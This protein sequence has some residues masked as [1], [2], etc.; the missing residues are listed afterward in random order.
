MAQN[1]TQHYLRTIDVDKKIVANIDNGIIILNTNLTIFHYNR[2]LELHTKIKES[3]ILEKSLDELFPEIKTKTLIRKIKTALRLKTPTFYTATI[4]KYL[5]PIELNQIQNSH[6]EY[7]QQDVSII[8]F[9]EDKEL[10]AL[11]LTDQ[12]NMIQTNSLLEANIKKV[13]ELNAELLK[14]KKTI[15][16]KVLFI[17]IDISA[18]IVDLSEALLELLAFEKDELLTLNFFTYEQRHMNEALKIKILAAMKELRVFE[19]EHK[20][21]SKDGKTIWLKN[22][23][24]PECDSKGNHFGFIIFRENITA[25]KNL[26]INHEKMLANSR[27][28][29]MGEM[30]GMIAHQW[31]Q[32]LSLINTV[33]AT[34][35]I[36][37]ELNVLDENTINDSFEKIQNTTQFLS[38]TIDDFREYF[39]PN[40]LTSTFTLMSLFDKSIFFLKE[41]MDQHDISYTTKIDASLKITTYKNELLQSIINIIK[42]SIDA[43][44]DTHE[45]IDKRYIEVEVKQYETH[46][47]IKIKDNAGG[48]DS[49]ILPRVFEPYFSTKSKNGTGLGLYMCKAI[50]SEHLKGDIHMRSEEKTTS[51][52]IE[53]PYKIQS[54]G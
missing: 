21:L 40:K 52:L 35:K 13:Q 15:D 46:I 17:K 47:S 5:I 1:E 27:S 48:I 12:T 33:I 23:I 19:F 39:K 18:T 29:A 20:T 42:N 44:T 49:K 22:S 16:E 31:R 14:E 34:M 37:K 43:F 11:I 26:V 45:E 6:F 28:A 2:W 4:S 54:Q 32:P 41:E 8:P 7:M 36:K 24:V 10:V 50:I 53:L 25:S 51:T 3:D 9:D 30:I 38:D